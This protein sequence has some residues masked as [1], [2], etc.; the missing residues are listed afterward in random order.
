MIGRSVHK[1]GSC[2]SLKEIG[3]ERDRDSA[4]IGEL[5]DNLFG[6]SC[7][8]VVV[9]GE[10]IS[11]RGE[12][13]GDRRTDATPAPGHQ[14]HRLFVRQR[15]HGASLGSAGVRAPRRDAF[16]LQQQ[17]LGRHAHRA[18]GARPVGRAVRVGSPARHQVELLR[19]GKQPPAIFG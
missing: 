14:G 10:A 17:P 3:T 18:D 15:R 16:L 12:R 11:S 4:S 2:W 1:I 5:G 8:G 9:Y 6:V 13:S 7:R 19:N